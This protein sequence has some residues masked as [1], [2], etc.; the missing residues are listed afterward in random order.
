VAWAGAVAC[1]LHGLDPA[2]GSP[3]APCVGAQLDDP[4]CAAR[5]HRANRLPCQDSLDQAVTAKTCG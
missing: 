2:S 5:K 3:A 4:E 1:A